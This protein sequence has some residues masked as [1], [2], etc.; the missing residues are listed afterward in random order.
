MWRTTSLYKSQ[1]YALPVIPLKLLYN[2]GRWNSDV[3]V[4]ACAKMGTGE[5]LWTHKRLHTQTCPTGGTLRH[6]PYALCPSR[7]VLPSCSLSLP[8]GTGR[9][10]PTPTEATA[11]GRASATKP[12]R[13][14]LYIAPKA[15]LLFELE[16]N[17]VNKV[18]S[19][20]T[21]P[22]RIFSLELNVYFY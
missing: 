6:G 2:A 18:I 19:V 12:C 4:P 17:N 11:A 14:I 15:A 13:E 5:E 16:N 9:S 10:A 7:H 8:R 22:G 3:N 1:R 20:C 21:I